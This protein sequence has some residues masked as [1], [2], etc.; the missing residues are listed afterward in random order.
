MFTK[1]FFTKA[2][3]F[4]CFDV[5]SAR[6]LQICQ[7]QAKISTVRP[8]FSDY[9]TIFLFLVTM[10]PGIYMNTFIVCRIADQKVKM[11]EIFIKI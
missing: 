3:I 1:Q 9:S 4:R 2:A 11:K 5:F 10:V 7:I 6:P 8:V